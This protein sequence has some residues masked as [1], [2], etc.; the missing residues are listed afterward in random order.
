MFNPPR[1]EID[2][3]IRQKA[4]ERFIRKFPDI[5]EQ[6]D[7]RSAAARILEFHRLFG[8]SLI[9]INSLLQLGDRQAA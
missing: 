7:E 5:Q 8:V 2:D 9:D 4:A 1:P 3:D 6:Y